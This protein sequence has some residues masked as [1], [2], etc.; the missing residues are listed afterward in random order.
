MDKQPNNIL[1]KG[2]VRTIYEYVISIRTLDIEKAADIMNE[3]VK[4]ILS[5]L[6]ATMG[7]SKETLLDNVVKEF[8]EHGEKIK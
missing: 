8:G 1:G 5:V 7:M 6:T 3:K 2:T 4:E